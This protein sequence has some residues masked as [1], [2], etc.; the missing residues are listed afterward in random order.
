MA[1]CTATRLL[2][3]YLGFLCA[4][5]HKGSQSP[6][7]RYPSLGAIFL[8]H[9][10]VSAVILS[11]GL[12]VV[13]VANRA[14]L[15]RKARRTLPAE[16][17]RQDV[18]VGVDPVANLLERLEQH[19]GHCGIFTADEWGGSVIGVKWKPKAFV[20]G[21]MRVPIAHTLSPVPEQETENGGDVQYVVDKA[22]VLQEVIH[23][24]EGMV[25]DAVLIRGAE[26]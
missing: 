14:R 12:P 10:L 3:I 16:V 6:W 22:V 9:Q 8:L 23:C 24:G 5:Q 7:G 4:L 11:A 19:L 1:I 21:P 18:L 13:C 17:L 26:S 20:P 25:D 15:Y 2:C